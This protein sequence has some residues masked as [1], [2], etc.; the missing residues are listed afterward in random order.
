MT[1]KKERPRGKKIL[2]LASSIVAI[3]VL[4]VSG[5]VAVINIIILPRITA[6][7]AAPFDPEGK[8]SVKIGDIRYWP[9]YGLVV[10]NLAFTRGG[11]EQSAGF[12]GG[13]APD[14]Q[15]DEKTVFD[16]DITSAEISVA[17]IR[18]PF[19]E[20]VALR[21]IH[22]LKT[23]GLF[24]DERI[25]ETELYRFTE[26]IAEAGLFPRKVFF[27]GAG[28]NVEDPKTYL[29]D[30]YAKRIELTHIP[31]ESTIRISAL[32]STG[33][34]LGVNA[35]INYVDE[36]AS[37]NLRI[38]PLDLSF[39]PFAGGK[40][41]IDLSFSHGEPQ[42]IEVSGILTASGVVLHMPSVSDENIGGI[43]LLYEFDAV[44]G[45]DV[46]THRFSGRSPITSKPPFTVQTTDQ[47][48][49][50]EGK[51]QINGIALDFA[52]GYFGLLRGP[53][54][55]RMAVQLPA[56]EIQSII[57][58]VPEAISGRLSRTNTTGSIA[59]GLDLRIPMDRISEMQWES[60]VTLDNFSVRSMDVSM[61]V[62]ELNDEFIH[63]IRDGSTVFH[64]T[65]QIPPAKPASMEWML[66]HSEHTQTQ[67]QRSREE[68]RA[69]E[70]SH[71]EVE[72]TAASDLS[73]SSPQ[74]GE[75]LDASYRYCYVDDI[76][77]WIVSAVLTA[78][79][80]DF[81]F[82]GGINPVTFSDAIAINLEAGDIVVGA[83]TISMQV[84]KILFLDQSRIFS[85]KIQEA[86]LVYLMEHQVPVSKERI[87]ELYL[88]LAEFGPRIYGVHDASEHYFGKDPSQLTA[89]EATWLA[90]I[91][92]SPKTYYGQFE[93]GR[94]SPNSRRRMKSLY[95]IMLER[96]R[97]SAAEYEQA[98][99]EVPRFAPRR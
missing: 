57:D 41:S 18:I 78:E 31:D 73:G 91:L 99:A 81:F 22:E 13:A 25:S 59:Y 72:S 30:I 47:F 39:S 88:N 35:R 3:A 77:P 74:P 11:A 46:T 24:G 10:R 61:N 28:V 93:E 64:R 67:I 6:N 98:V 17:K 86:F 84:I 32:E 66:K 44:Y 60:E 58:G 80:G 21:W 54:V 1:R 20:P 96:G 34:T 37:G 65:V 45:G 23:G 95:R 51:L 26:R 83:S 12:S 82:Y 62:Y 92:P 89:A 15:P 7:L 33:D 56:T 90:S 16:I 49:V 87:L 55:L 27:R 48:I 43:D 50:T 69:I 19:A 42:K 9:F 4:A 63:T 29:L 71:P 75:T 5:A 8:I 53:S 2:L 68:D 85:R 38:A 52:P 70:A 76:S 14:G 79:D 40:A 36:T 97:M 94:I